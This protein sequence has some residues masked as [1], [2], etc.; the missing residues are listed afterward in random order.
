MKTMRDREPS[1]LPGDGPPPVPVLF[2]HGIWDTGAIFRPMIE[3]LRERGFTHLEAIDLQPPDAS[4]P[5]SAYAEQVDAAARKLL[6]ESGATRLD[7]VGFSMGTLVARWWLVKLG[8]R[9][10]ARRFVSISGPQHGTWTAFFHWNTGAAD[11]RPGS[12]FLHALES[13]PQGFGGVEVVSMWTPLDLM[14]I[15]ASSG[16]LAG[17]AQHKFW[18][19]L[20]PLMP[21]AAKVIDAVAEA[22]LRPS[23]VAEEP[24]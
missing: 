4:V 15:P 22:L 23:E 16:A 13:D 14:I 2:V 19:P 7:I 1:P 6:A 5:L 20:H 3:R 17:S 8:G 11:M 21:A 10:R 24:Q 9:E 18:V 12:E